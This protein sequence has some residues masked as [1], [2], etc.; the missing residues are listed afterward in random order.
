[1]PIPPKGQRDICS[2]FPVGIINQTQPR[3]RQF[4]PTAFV[5]RI[6]R[7]IAEQNTDGSCNAGRAFAH[8]VLAT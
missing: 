6:S 2:Q 8:K 1:M 7:P 4:D 5:R 3:S